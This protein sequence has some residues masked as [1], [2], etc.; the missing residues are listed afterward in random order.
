ML[1][2]RHLFLA[3]VLFSLNASAI[4]FITE[5]QVAQRLGAQKVIEISKYSIETLIAPGSQ[6]DSAFPSKSARAYV[7]KHGHQASLYLTVSGL[8]ELSRCRDL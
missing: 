6:C 8:S 4:E 5:A 3:T 2:V 1:K 7:V